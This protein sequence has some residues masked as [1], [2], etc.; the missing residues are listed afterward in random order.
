MTL[1]NY[2]KYPNSDT[3]HTYLKTR[4]HEGIHALNFQGLSKPVCKTLGYHGGQI[5]LHVSI[6]GY[7]FKRRAPFLADDDSPVYN[8]YYG[9]AVKCLQNRNVCGYSK[10]E[11]RPVLMFGNHRNTVSVTRSFMNTLA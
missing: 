3:A 8:Q 11:F 2:K 5:L 10:T 7:F 9:T 6:A 4:F 1:T